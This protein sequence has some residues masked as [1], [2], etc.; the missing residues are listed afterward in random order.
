[1]R[2]RVTEQGVVIPKK[3]LPDVEEVEIRAENGT[4]LVLPVEREDP[5][6]GLGSAPV[7]CGTPDASEH[8]DRDLYG[9]CE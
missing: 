6:L 3:M 4:V 8:H 1:M 2:A 5:I 7:E 9:S